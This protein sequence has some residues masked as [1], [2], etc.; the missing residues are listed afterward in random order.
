MNESTSIKCTENKY[1]EGKIYRIDPINIRDVCDVYIGSTIKSLEERMKGHYYNYNHYMN[2]DKKCGTRSKDLFE[3]YG[4]E[5]CKISLI[6][7]HPCGSRKQ[8]HKKEAFYIN[9]I[10]CVNKSMKGHIEEGFKCL[11]C[12][13]VSKT[14]CNLS[15]HYLTKTHIRKMHGEVDEIDISSKTQCKVCYQK[16]KSVSGL[17]YHNKTCKAVPNI[18]DD[19]NALSVKAYNNWL[20]SQKFVFTSSRKF[21]NIEIDSPNENITKW[22]EL[23]HWLPLAFEGFERDLVKGFI[24]DMQNNYGFVSTEDLYNSKL[25]GQL[26]FEAL[27]EI[28]GFKIGHFNRLTKRLEMLGNSCYQTKE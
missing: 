19:L 16:Y 4:V 25:E 21:E 12:N 28:D 5:N 20:N 11:C 13:F 10:Q 18:Q 1:S 27:K 15:K 3:K 24:E 9:T 14:N 26:T 17:W 7:L 22:L 2:G 6:E 8:L 23:N